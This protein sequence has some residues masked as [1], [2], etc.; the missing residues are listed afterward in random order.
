MGKLLERIQYELRV[1]ATK[2]PESELEIN[3]SQQCLNRI[4]SDWAY[5]RSLAPAPAVPHPIQGGTLLGH[6]F[7][8]HKLAPPDWF[9]I[10]AKEPSGKPAPAGECTLINPPPLTTSH[11]SHMQEILLTMMRGETI[12]ETRELHGEWQV[13]K[14]CNAKDLYLS[15]SNNIEYRVYEDAFISDELWGRIPSKITSVKWVDHPVRLILYTS[16]QESPESELGG[17]T[18][19]V[20]GFDEPSESD[21]HKLI[22]RPTIK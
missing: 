8:V 17:F 12:V 21:F 3:L 5:F 22:E 10:N 6:K 20:L 2:Y 19:S 18:L 4:V 16:N 13:V 9:G 1:Q 11:E 14:P 7:C 15:L